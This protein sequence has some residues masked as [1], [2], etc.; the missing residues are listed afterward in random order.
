MTIL[1]TSDV[2]QTSLCEGP[3][4]FIKFNSYTIQLKIT[5][6][7]AYIENWVYRNWEIIVIIQYNFFLPVKL[8]QIK[9]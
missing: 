7:D 3:E 9:L 1:D 8:S 4:N 5:T 2:T 6:Y